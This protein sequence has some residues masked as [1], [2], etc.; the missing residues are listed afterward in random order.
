MAK[1]GP[2]LA[3]A[4]GALVLSGC[5]APAYQVPKLD[6]TLPQTYKEVGPWTP[7]APSDVAARG[8]WWTA[9]GDQRLDELE[10]RLVAS[11]PDLAQALA[12]YDQARDLL[13]QTRADMFPQVGLNAQTAREQV[14]GDSLANVRGAQ[15]GDNN[16][17]GGFFSYEID[18]W[19]RVRNE[20]AAARANTQASAGDLAATR[21]SLQAQLADTYL[22]LRSLDA[23]AA[24][25]DAA[26][27]NFAKA[28]ALTQTLHAG[29]AVPGMDV[30]QAEDQLQ[31]AEA[32]RTEVLAQRALME[33]AIASLVGLPATV[34]SLPVAADLPPLP[35]TP[36]SAPSVLLQRRPDVAAA[37]RRAFAANRRIGVARAAFFPTISLGGTGGFQTSNFSQSFLSA[38]AAYWLIGPQLAMT[39]FDGG[40][41]AAVV[42]GARDFF[43]EESAAYRS[44]V[45]AAFQQVEDNLAL[46]NRLARESE[47]EQAALVAAKRTLDLALTQYRMGATTYLNVVTAQ[48]SELDAERAVVQLQAR[49]L[50]A[51]VDLVRALG[52]GW[53]DTEIGGPPHE[54]AAA[55]GV[56]G[57]APA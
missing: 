33:H 8:D 23:Q 55:K 2:W 14:S 46:L 29:G 41:R 15:I 21:L 48:T 7:A 54:D 45:L 49:R 27:V 57:R 18:L 52:G 11:N 25:L 53:T 35:A 38:P 3:A 20:V 28:L 12:R 19:G 56:K 22:G 40:R 37:E 36:V 51:S 32:A 43:S 50:Q 47:Q 1:L 44:T 34:F 24:I 9:F 30:A 6:A 42:A 13:R 26:V 10:G 31:T 5:L 4:S 17:V 39:L 16:V